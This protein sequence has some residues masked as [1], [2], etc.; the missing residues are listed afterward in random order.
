MSAMMGLPQNSKP[1]PDNREAA[2]GHCSTAGKITFRRL[3]QAALL[4]PIVLVLLAV[5]GVPAAPASQPRGIDSITT[6]TADQDGANLRH[7]SSLFY[8]HHAQELYLINGGAGRVVV[9][10]ADFFPVATIGP[11]RGVDAP[12]GVFVTPDGMVYIVQSNSRQN[13]Y[14]RITILNGAFFV[15]REIILNE[16]PEAAEFAPSQVAVSRDGLIYLS[17]STKRG[18]LVLDNE[19]NFLRRLEP[20]DMISDQEAIAAAAAKREES[21]QWPASVVP[22][23]PPATEIDDLDQ[24]RSRR[25]EEAAQ[26]E[27]EFARLTEEL[28]TARDIWADIPEEFRPRTEE[29]REEARVRRGLGPPRIN[30]VVIDREGNLFLV[31]AETGR[32]YVYSPEE[33]FLYAFGEKGGTPGKMSQP[34]GVAVDERRNLIFVNDYMRHTI[35]AYDFNGRFRFEAG[36]YGN[37]PGWFNFPADIAI[38]RQNQFVIADLFNRRVQVLEIRDRQSTADQQEKTEPPAAAIVITDE[39][40]LLT[41]TPARPA[42]AGDESKQE[43][44]NGGQG[45]SS[46]EKLQ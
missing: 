15:E 26:R 20:M 38:T 45:E 34:R 18:V 23:A 42:F 13:P 3:F 39:Q 37:A 40:N 4:L 10:G 33:T 5:A 44:T 16:I 12:R 30:R 2:A 31:S 1:A 6:I 11:G 35:L 22:I 29:E 7:P 46:D 32:I 41:D 21:D 14:N 8:D 36:G 9:Y 27:K 17:G 24:P 28:E 43:A 19:G 25:P